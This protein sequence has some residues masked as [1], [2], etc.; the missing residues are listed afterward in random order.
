MSVS[1]DQAAL[2]ELAKCF[3]C[4]TEPQIQA[5]KTWLLCQIANG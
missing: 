1:C 5:I 4:L 2:E 3:L